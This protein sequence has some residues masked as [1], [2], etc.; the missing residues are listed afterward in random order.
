MTTSV[1][2]PPVVSVTVMLAVPA[3]S[4]LTVKL[5]DAPGTTVATFVLSDFADNVAPTFDDVAVK[6]PA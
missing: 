6:V 1:A 3:L 2:L 4:E 5:P